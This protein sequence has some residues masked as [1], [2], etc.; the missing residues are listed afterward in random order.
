MDYM[1]ES[2]SRQQA[3][4]AVDLCIQRSGLVVGHDC[5]HLIPKIDRARSSDSDMIGVGSLMGRLTLWVGRLEELL[6]WIHVEV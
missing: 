6:V 2:L 1:S 4:F 5:L 3:E